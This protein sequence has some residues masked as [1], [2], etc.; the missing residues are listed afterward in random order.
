MLKLES[1]ALARLEAGEVSLGASVRIARAVDIAPLMQ[2]CGFDWLFLDLEHS[3]LPLDTAAQISIAALSV[4][5]T[6]IVRI[7]IG[8]FSIATR[9]LDSGA[10][11]IVH[12]HIETAEEARRLVD[13]V[14]FPPIGHRG[15]GGSIPQFGYQPVKLGEAIAELNRATLITVML[16][17]PEA[18]AQAD[19]IA[20][21]EGVDVVMIGTNDLA[22]AMGYPQQ[23][24]HPEVV[25]AYE[26]VAAA[27]KRHG[28]YL[29]SGGVQD[30]EL[31][32]RYV[33]IGVRFLL[34]GGDSTL[35]LGAG[36]QR[37]ET[38]RKINVG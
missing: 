14:C 32:S 11:G 20:A 37:V 28:K 19:E 7:P 2:T 34:A 30:P 18:V 23:F 26:T 24:G 5:I 6:P 15:V 10:M 1:P 21:V 38:L 8:G 36:R 9:V 17:T 33:G 25:K 3:A 35:L 12:P 4:G 31:I 13:A 29:G 22:M 16:E 27:C